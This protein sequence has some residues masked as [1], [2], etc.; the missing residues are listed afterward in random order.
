MQGAIAFFVVAGWVAASPTIRAEA[1]K[2]DTPSFAQKPSEEIK[3]AMGRYFAALRALKQAQLLKRMIENG[4]RRISPAGSYRLI[5]SDY[6]LEIGP[7]DMPVYR[8]LYANFYSSPR[9]FLYLPEPEDKRARIKYRPS[10]FEYL[11]PCWKNAF[12]KLLTQTAAVAP[13]GEGLANLIA[14]GRETVVYEK[15]GGYPVLYDNCYR[16]LPQLH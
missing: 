15:W 9:H 2:T 6:E 13:K 5:S 16:N 7:E 1:V 12:C 10:E 14:W 4:I 3:V 11:Y 8:A